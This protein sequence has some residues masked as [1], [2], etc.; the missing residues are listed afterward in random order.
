MDGIEEKEGSQTVQRHINP[1]PLNEASPQISPP[2]T[3]ESKK[4]LQ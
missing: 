1:M 2:P 4:S 3:Q